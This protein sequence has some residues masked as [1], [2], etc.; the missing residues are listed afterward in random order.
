MKR[1]AKEKLSHRL[2]YKDEMTSFNLKSIKTTLIYQTYSFLMEL[3]RAKS[4]LKTP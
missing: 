3:W 2:I 4:K 1:E